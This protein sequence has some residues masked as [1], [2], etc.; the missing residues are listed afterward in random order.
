[1]GA[2]GLV[3]NA[4]AGALDGD[5]DPIALEPIPAPLPAAVVGAAPSGVLK[6]PLPAMLEVPGGPELADEAGQYVVVVVMRIVE[7]D[8]PTEMLVTPPEVWVSVTGQR[9]VEVTMMTVVIVVPTPDEDVLV[10][11]VCVGEVL[12]ADPLLPDELWHV[13]EVGPELIQVHTAL[14]ESST[15]WSSE[16][17]QAPM[18][19][20]VASLVIVCTLAAVH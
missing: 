8:T 13:T 20:R 4:L 16:E 11:L 19:Q 7:V 18:T 1:V 3:K 2:A 10:G 17:G 5:P 6:P 9:V 15:A 12:D 14:V